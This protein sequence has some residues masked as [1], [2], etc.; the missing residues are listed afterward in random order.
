[1][2]FARIEK[3]HIILAE[4]EEVRNS[5]ESGE[6]IYAISTLEAI[7]AVKD[8]KR[9]DDALWFYSLVRNGVE[10]RWVA[11]QDLTEALAATGEDL[12]GYSAYYSKYA[13]YGESTW[14]NIYTIASIKKVAPNSWDSRE[15]YQVTTSKGDHYEEKFPVDTQILLVKL[16][17]EEFAKRTVKFRNYG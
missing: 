17:D 7:L 15:L 14:E 16:S 12:V 6:S 1:M 3:D 4:R 8:R 9:L 5:Q 2:T 13:P 10:H 11:V